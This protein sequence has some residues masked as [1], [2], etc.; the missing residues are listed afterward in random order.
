MDF[1]WL[2]H[3]DVAGIN[4]PR[5]LTENFPRNPRT[6][7]WARG[8]PTLQTTLKHGA[9]MAANL[10]H[11]ESKHRAGS[12]FSNGKCFFVLPKKAGSNWHSALLSN[13]LGMDQYLLIPFLVG[14]TSIYQLFVCSPGVQGFDP[15]PFRPTQKMD[16]KSMRVMDWPH[17]PLRQ[18][19]DSVNTVNTVNDRDPIESMKLHL[20]GDFAR[21]LHVFYCLLCIVLPHDNA[22]PMQSI[23]GVYMDYKLSRN[24]ND[25]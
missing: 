17:C 25:S 15:L 10:N 6:W 11:P 4:P 9:R 12:T 5:W 20:D 1:P 22:M 2:S 13:Y 8:S 19:G 24:I 16:Q 18:S 3:D 23:V 14:W 21:F 7:W